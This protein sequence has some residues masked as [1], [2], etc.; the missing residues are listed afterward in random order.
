LRYLI[1][2][3]LLALPERLIA[4]AIVLMVARQILIPIIIIAAPAGKHAKPA[5]LARTG[6]ANPLRRR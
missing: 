1:K 4:I 2:R 5:T 6:I 3:K